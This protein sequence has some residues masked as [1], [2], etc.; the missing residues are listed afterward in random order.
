MDTKVKTTKTGAIAVEASLKSHKVVG[1]GNLR[2][3][4]VPDGKFWFAHGLEIDYGAQGDSVDDAKRNFQEGLL[5]TIEMHLKVNGNIDELLTF[6]PS[7][8]LREASKKKNSIELYM[9]V[10]AHEISEEFEQNFLFAGID[11]LKAAA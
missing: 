11:Y 2:V 6:A 8:V 1:I 10:S 3:L 9:H 5:K 7:S 4:I